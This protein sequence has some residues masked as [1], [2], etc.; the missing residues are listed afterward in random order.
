MENVDNKQNYYTISYKNQP[1]HHL[2]KIKIFL[3]NKFQT[4]FGFVQGN[5]DNRTYTGIAFTH[6][7]GKLLKINYFNNLVWF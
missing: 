6:I 2:S 4:L 1:S 5:V 3:F 7:T